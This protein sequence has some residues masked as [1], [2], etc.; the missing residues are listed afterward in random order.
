MT[1]ARIQCVVLFC[2]RTT[3]RREFDEWICG[4]H[5][6]LIP[7]KFRR[8]Y[9]RRVGMWRR[10]HRRQDGVVASTMWNWLKRKANLAAGGLR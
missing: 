2:R 3:A 4:D 9:G 5:W 8:A 7:K 1:E 6:Q 10:Y